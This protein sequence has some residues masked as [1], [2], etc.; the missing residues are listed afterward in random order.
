MFTP[1]NVSRVTCHMSHYYYYLLFIY[2]FRT[3]WWSL[4]VEG[5]LSTGPT[6]PSF[7]TDSVY[8]GVC[9]L[10][11]TGQQHKR[12]LEILIGWPIQALFYLL[13]LFHNS[14]Y[15]V[16]QCKVAISTFQVSNL[17]LIWRAYQKGILF[18]LPG[19][20]EQ[21]RVYVITKAVQKAILTKKTCR[22]F[23]HQVFHRL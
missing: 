19:L 14:F 4:S 8:T 23:F 1:P 20:R 21:F 12:L 10:F 3:K 17:T 16:R 9:D 13:W 15:H 7:L 5:L 2:F 6:T 11:E 22:C 18:C